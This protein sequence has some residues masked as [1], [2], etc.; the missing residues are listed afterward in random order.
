[1]E[2]WLKIQTQIKHGNAV[3]GY[4][5]IPTPKT[6]FT[7]DYDS[8]KQLLQQK[9]KSGSQNNSKWQT[10]VQTKLDK[11]LLA[12]IRSFYTSNKK[13]KDIQPAVQTILANIQAMHWFHWVIEFPDILE[14]GG[15]D[16][17]IG[18]PPYL[19][20]SSSKVQK[21]QLQKKVL[22]VFY[23][24]LDDLYETFVQKAKDL[25]KGLVCYIIPTSF[26]KQIGSRMTRNL[27]LYE[28]LGENVFKGVN[29]SFCIVQ[30]DNQSHSA[31]TFRSYLFQDQK[32]A[33]LGQGSSQQ[34]TSFSFFLDH[35]ILQFIDQHSDRFETYKLQVKRGEE[36]GRKNTRTEYSPD[37]IP[38]FSAEELIAF[39]LRSPS[40][41]IPPTLIEKEADFYNQERIGV[42]LAFRHKL[43]AAYIGKVFSLK[44]IISIYNGSY[45][46]LL[47]ILGW[48]NSTLF[49]WYHRQRYCTYTE[50]RANQIKE[51]KSVYP[52]KITNNLPL[53][54]V[55]EYLI[56]ED[57]P[58]FRQFL[59]ALI[60]DQY[61]YTHFFQS[62]IYPENEPILKQRFEKYCIELN[63]KTW[64][65]AYMQN[66]SK[67]PDI[68]IGKDKFDRL[69]HDILDNQKKILEQINTDETIGKIIA[70]IQA[71][72]WILEIEHVKKANY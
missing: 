29:A 64:I 47:E 63:I 58:D 65:N 66:I 57:N 36:Y 50:L 59:D 52:L 38:I 55:V 6:L 2:I 70:Q 20:F 51:I 10:E 32:L 21:D 69:T 39:K 5:K 18:N 44:S 27:R 67:S 16:L 24:Q 7:Q 14:N 48:L 17:I 41:F 56:V 54:R 35:P 19:S 34:V 12:E 15:F 26:Y 62:K 46:T 22:D 40:Y 49:D 42:N 13:S 60:Y 53:I 8:V 1:L 68:A 4:T 45:P 61:L 37:T 71:D 72:P 30:F 11:L 3:V 9:R 43:K 28:N 33:T 23:P 25:C 31:F